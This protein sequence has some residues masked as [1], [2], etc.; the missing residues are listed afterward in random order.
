[1]NM[2][3]LLC[4][5]LALLTLQTASFA[6]LWWKKH[7]PKTSRNDS[8]LAV[9]KKQLYR[10][11]ERHQETEITLQETQTYLQ[12]L[13]DSMPSILIG[14]DSEGAITHWNKSAEEASGLTLKEVF[15]KALQNAFPS[16]PVNMEL[17]QRTFKSGE[18]QYCKNIK[19]GHGS[20]ANYTD[21]VVYPLRISNEVEEVV[22]MA[23]DV[24][25]RVHIE[26]RLIQSDKMQGLGE[27]AAG[28]AHEI[29]NPLAGILH[30]TQNIKRRTSPTLKNNR[31]VADRL[32]IDMDAVYRYLYER[33]IL[34]FVDNIQ[35]AGER[36]S[37][38]VSNMLNFARS[39]PVTK[40]ETDLLELSQYAIELTLNSYKPSEYSEIGVPEIHCDFDA[41]TPGVECAPVEIQQL[42]INLLRNALQSFEND[43][44][45]KSNKPE[46]NLSITHDSSS[47]KIVVSDNG[48]GISEEVRQHIFEPFFTTK[49][50]GQGTGLGLSVCYFIVREHHDGEIEVESEVGK[51]TRF[52]VTLPLSHSF[53]SDKPKDPPPAAQSEPK[54]YHPQI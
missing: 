1:M 30:H 25:H 34:S 42:L 37:Q 26:N 44:F 51:G 47:A 36:A 19:R 38:I 18:P 50:T 6:W 16:L 24:S 29:N 53:H 12:A 31:E 52:I 17:I 35:I 32:G 45:D 21:L 27:M 9:T 54:E 28:L 3:L 5:A 49:Q 39:S 8:N 48:P 23:T 33:N 15:G 43:E 40:I 11:I 41:S 14:V 46:V 7:K 4:F 2:E 20:R 10:E 13:I 22:I